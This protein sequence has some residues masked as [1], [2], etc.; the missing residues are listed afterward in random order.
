MKELPIK[1][2]LKTLAF[3]A[4]GVMAMMQMSCGDNETVTIHR[5]DTELAHGEIPEDSIRLA[6][7]V[8]LFEISGL[9]NLDYFEVRDYALNPSISSH[10]DA[11]EKAFPESEINKLGHEIGHAFSGMR[12][13]TPQVKIPA[14]FTIISPF[15]QSIFVADSMVYIGLNHYLGADYEPYGYFPEYLRTQKVR[16]RLVPDVVEAL[17]RSS[18]PLHRSHTTPVTTLESLVYDGAVTEAIMRVTGAHER[19]AIGYTKDQMD[20]VKDNE[21]N[22]WNTLIEKEL[23]FSSDPSIGRSLLIPGPHTSVIT[24]SSPGRAGRFTAHRLVKSYLD[25]NKDVTLDQLLKLEIPADATFLQK[26]QY[27]P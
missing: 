22:I 26:A 15:S 20:W 11:V 5:L 27:K 1:H 13:E 18:Y 23:L 9:D 14:V 8:R 4:L 24:Q 25:N 10:L 21:K 19:E 2:P 6:A 3:A 16:D 12:R 17:V 7:A